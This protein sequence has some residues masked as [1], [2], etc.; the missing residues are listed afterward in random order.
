MDTKY[1]N[2]ILTI[3]KKQN[4]TKAA[5][6]L[7]VSQSSLSQYLTKLEAE[8]GAPLFIRAKGKLELTEAG[9]LYIDAARK[10]IDIKNDL[11]YQIRSLN[12]KSHI[13]IGITSI[14]GLE[15]LTTLIPQY[16]KDFPDVTIEIT[17]T[18]IP[19]ITTLILEE[20]IDCAV[21]AINDM[22]VFDPGQLTHLGREEVLLAVPA[23]HPFALTHK[24]GSSI[25]WESF[26]NTFNA[27]NFILS[28]KA[29]SLR[30][31]SNRIFNEIGFEPSTMCE[32]NSILT[33]RSMVEMGIGIAFIAKTCAN[34][35]NNICYFSLDPPIYRDVAFVHR[36]GWILN[37]P[38]KALIEH[39]LQ[40]FAQE[41]IRAQIK[42]PDIQ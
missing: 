12:H 5:E 30:V 25:S 10:V 33:I 6:E 13:T 23:S 35:N 1:L 39:I 17:E 38:E 36:K 28:K 3:A 14:F 27:D 15:M 34:E 4:M 7:F 18:N 37:T 9:K 41:K 24:S 16:K 32:T 8:I 2:Y 29:S 26:A 40:Y 42:A 31:L 19:S 20:S 11:Y 21:I 22:S